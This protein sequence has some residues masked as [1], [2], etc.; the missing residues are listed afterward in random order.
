MN[1]DFNFKNLEV[2]QKALDFADFVI[3]I[4]KN[5]N[6]SKNQFRLLEQ[7]EA[8]SASISQNIAEGKGRQTD[9]DYAKSFPIQEVRFTKQS[10]YC[11]YF[12]KGNGY[13]SKHCTKPKLKPQ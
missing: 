8:S 10:L 13:P 3:E 12:L 9:K 6:T 7:I 2:W 1:N 4:T 5:L 11:I